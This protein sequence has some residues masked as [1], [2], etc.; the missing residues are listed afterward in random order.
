MSEI[1]N[2]LE[3]ASISLLLDSYDAIFSDFDPRPFSER[4]ISDDFLTET[5]KATIENKEGDLELRFLIPKHL[6]NLHTDDIIRS[7]LHHHFKKEMQSLE[8]QIKNL[9]ISGILITVFGMT[10]LLL[11]SLLVTIEK[12]AF[13]HELLK[14]IF[15][16]AGWFAV[17]FGLDRIFY[18]VRD[19]HSKLAYYQRMAKAEIQF[20]AYQNP[21]QTISHIS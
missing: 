10:L 9:M 11:I 18:F 16:P 12:P 15:E 19:Q 4:G 2:L 8:S 20:E 13:W 21:P 5:K 17:W 3:K 1:K 6:H 7:R 14:V